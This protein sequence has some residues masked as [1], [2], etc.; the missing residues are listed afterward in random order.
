MDCEIASVVLLPRND[1]TTQ[2]HGERDGVSGEGKER[3]LFLVLM[4]FSLFLALGRYNPLYSLVFKYVPFFNGIRYPAKFLY[5]FFLVLSI[6]A[7][8]GFQRLIELSVML[9]QRRLKNLPILLSLFSGLFL[10]LLIVGHQ[11]IFHF[12]KGKESRFP[13]FQ[14]S[15]HQPL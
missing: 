1:I 13:G 4:L 14:S 11:E 12:L 3:K 15:R 6:T 10:L 7:G 5:L 8:L 2:S 9:K